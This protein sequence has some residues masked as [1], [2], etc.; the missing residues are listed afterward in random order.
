MDVYTN[1]VLTE[2]IGN[3]LLIEFG[4]QISPLLVDETVSLRCIDSII[5]QHLNEKLKGKL[6]RSNHLHLEIKTSTIR[7]SINYN[8][9]NGRIEDRYAGIASD[10]AR[11]IHIE[12]K[13]SINIDVR[14]QIP[15]PQT[16][17]K[18]EPKVEK[19]DSSFYYDIKESCSDFSKALESYLKDE[20]NMQRYDKSKKYSKSSLLITFYVYNGKDERLDD[21][22]KLQQFG[23]NSIWLIFIPPE[24][25]KDINVRSGMFWYETNKRKLVPLKSEIKNEWRSNSSGGTLEEEFKNNIES[26]L[27]PYLQEFK[28]HIK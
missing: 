11:L 3:P 27:K 17:V 19:K 15:Q 18:V 10:L 4:N 13:F 16:T 20:L 14:T 28:K 24:V 23:G 9:V 25:K 7:S 26:K 6:E 21:G 8:I 1:Q 12:K 5:V 2:P 22:E